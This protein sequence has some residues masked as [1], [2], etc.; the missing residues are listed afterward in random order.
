MTDMDTET[1]RTAEA[2]RWAL[3]LSGDVRELGRLFSDALL[4]AHSDSSVDTKTSYLEALTDG[5]LVYDT[6]DC[7]ITE[8][9]CEAGCTVFMGTMKADVRRNGK[10]LKL[11]S[12][13]TTVWVSAPD[14]P[15]LLAHKSTPL[16]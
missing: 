15:R 6:L 14:G 10:S 8:T 11:N 7:T 12:S 4:Y 1:A 9:A 5:S 16:A 13:Y 2:R 3:M